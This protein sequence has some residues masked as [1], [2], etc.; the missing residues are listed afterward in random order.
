MGSFGSSSSKQKSS[1]GINSAFMPYAMDA[2]NRAEQVGN[3]GYTPYMGN[4]VAVPQSLVNSWQGAADRSATFNTPGKAAPNIAAS[5]PLTTK[6][7]IQGLSS[8]EGYQNQLEQLKKNAPGMYDYIRS[9][10]IDP[11]TGKAAVGADGKALTDRT[12]HTAADIQKA[13]AAQGGAGQMP[14]F[15]LMQLIQQGMKTGGVMGGNM[16]FMGLPYWSRT[17]G[18]PHGGMT[19]AYQQLFNQHIQNGGGQDPLAG[20]ISANKPTAPTN[21]GTKPG[22]GQ[23]PLAGFISANKPTAP[24]NTGT[25]P[26]VGSNA[27]SDKMGNSSLL[28]LGGGGNNAA[29]YKRKKFT[30]I[31]R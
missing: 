15:S 27:Y 11:V 29:N 16:A 14:N 23:D 21:T 25:K 24:T 28:G 13:A 2:L 7:G 20:F 12:M 19:S 9:F 18:N 5:M 1:S 31:G 22:G 10:A 8:Y 4:D 3:Q 26:G 30:S 17:A 6:D